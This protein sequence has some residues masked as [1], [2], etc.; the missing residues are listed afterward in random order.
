[1]SAARPE[2]PST[3]E[4]TRS[5]NDLAEQ[6]RLS[7]HKIEKS[8]QK[9]L[10]K[11]EES[12]LDHINERYDQLMQLNERVQKRLSVEACQTYIDLHSQDTDEVIATEQMIKSISDDI[13]QLRWNTSSKI[14]RVSSIEAAN[15]D[16]EKH[17]G[18]SPL[19]EHAATDTLK[20]KDKWVGGWAEQAALASKA[21]NANNTQQSKSKRLLRVEPCEKLIN[22]F[23][24]GAHPNDVKSYL[25]NF[26]VLTKKKGID[27]EQIAVLVLSFIESVDKNECQMDTLQ[28]MNIIQ[29]WTKKHPDGEFM[30]IVGIQVFVAFQTYIKADKNTVN[31]FSHLLTY[32]K[33][34]QCLNNESIQQWYRKGTHGRNYVGYRVARDMASKYAAEH[35]EL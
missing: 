15:D 12:Q 17:V 35:F 2:T 31:I 23:S 19:F 33:Q 22:L 8:R 34:N 26:F 3:C 27:P 10:K 7:L 5:L 4:L 9:A 20:T 13:W 32:F 14:L 29:Y 1:M 30:V 18:F 11:A 16:V 6:T 21:T 28:Y 24:S 25:K